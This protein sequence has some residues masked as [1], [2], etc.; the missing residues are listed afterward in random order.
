MGLIVAGL[1]K[2]NRKKTK[3]RFAMAF[4]GLALLVALAGCGGKPDNGTRP[5]IY[6]ISVTATSGSAQA[7]STMTLQVR[8]R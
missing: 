2:Q 1:S 8:H 5:G 4:S 7:T 3:L 6:T